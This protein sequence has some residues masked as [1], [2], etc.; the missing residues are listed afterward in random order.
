MI[1]DQGA[2]I[3][4]VQQRQS[5]PVIVACHSNSG[6]TTCP[7]RCSRAAPSLFG[8]HIAPGCAWAHCSNSILDAL[9]CTA[10]AL[11]LYPT[12]RCNHKL[13]L[14]YK[15][16]STSRWLLRV[17]AG[18]HLAKQCTGALLCHGRG[19]SGRL[20]ELRRHVR[21]FVHAS[22]SS[23]S[24]SPATRRLLLCSHGLDCW[25]HLCRGRRGC[26]HSGTRPH[27]QWRSC[28]PF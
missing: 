28:R 16:Y 10:L 19:H 27:V 15:V 24:R 3:V 12:H 14:C 4:T 20:T 6:H 21:M 26:N 22:H 11:L 13:L 2:L 25:P 7:L 18:L 17:R 1:G 23:C 5:S 8:I 9:P